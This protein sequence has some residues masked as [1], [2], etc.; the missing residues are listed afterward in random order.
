L[1]V[2]IHAVQVGRRDD[3]RMNRMVASFI[4]AAVAA[5]A[6]AVVAVA[7]AAIAVAVVAVAVAVAAVAAAVA[8]AVVRTAMD[9]EN[10]G[11]GK[12]SADV[13]SI[14]AER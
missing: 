10:G 2:C 12:D 3:E 14:F 5:V 11:D 1:L 6:V 8:V 9:S 4:A 7:V 13:E